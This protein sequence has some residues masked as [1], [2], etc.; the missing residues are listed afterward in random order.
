MAVHV[1]R[2]RCY[3]VSFVWELFRPFPALLSWLFRGQVSSSKRIGT[4]VSDESHRCQRRSSLVHGSVSLLNLQVATWH[5][6]TVINPSQIE[7]VL[8]EAS[9]LVNLFLAHRSRFDTIH[10]HD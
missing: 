3:K 10:R 8:H 9:H 2:W 7:F 5:L 4:S 6:V 1:Q